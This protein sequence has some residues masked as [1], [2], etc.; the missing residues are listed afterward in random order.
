VGQ[1]RR[2]KLIAA[3]PDERKEPGS[4]PVEQSTQ[5]TSK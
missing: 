2:E 5:A 4:N 3:K 1:L